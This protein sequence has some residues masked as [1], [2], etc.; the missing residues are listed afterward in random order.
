MIPT[1]AITAF[2]E[3]RALNIPVRGTWAA[4]RSIKPATLPIGNMARH[5]AKLALGPVAQ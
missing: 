4:T 3:R 2:R 5:K 1:A